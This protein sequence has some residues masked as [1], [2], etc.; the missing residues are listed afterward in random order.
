MIRSWRSWSEEIHLGETAVCGRKTKKSRWVPEFARV[1]RQSP[2]FRSTK[3]APGSDVIVRYARS[4]SLPAPLTAEQIIDWK[5]SGI[6]DSV[7]AVVVGRS[8]LP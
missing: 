4:V 2:D 8:S 3:D 5:N 6:P 1:G 7:L